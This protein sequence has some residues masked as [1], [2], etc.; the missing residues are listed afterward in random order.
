MYCKSSNVSVSRLTPPPPPPQYVGKDRLQ[1]KE[2]IE[3]KA[4]FS[5]H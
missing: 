1:T 4:N 2:T 5:T 3:K